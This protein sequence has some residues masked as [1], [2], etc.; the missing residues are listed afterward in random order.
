MIVL[1][2]GY[3]RRGL[4]VG[5]GDRPCSSSLFSGVLD[6]VASMPDRDQWKALHSARLTRVASGKESLARW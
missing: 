6:S 2:L 3:L 1:V 4:R 5:G